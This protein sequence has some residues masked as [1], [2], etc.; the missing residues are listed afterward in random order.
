LAIGLILLITRVFDQVWIVILLTICILVVVFEQIAKAKMKLSRAQSCI[1]QN[2]TVPCEVKS[3]VLGT[4]IRRSDFENSESTETYRLGSLT[5]PLT[6]LAKGKSFV[7]TLYLDEKGN[8]RVFEAF[9]YYS[10]LSNK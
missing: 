6:K 10:D 8:A 7:A 5:E 9:G 4:V 2:R 3:G 1:K